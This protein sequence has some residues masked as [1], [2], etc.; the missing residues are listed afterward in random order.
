M[1]P[2]RSDGSERDAAVVRLEFDRGTILCSHWPPSIDP[3]GL[4]GMRW[5]ERVGCFRAPARFHEAVRSALRAAA[6][7]CESLVLAPLPPPVPRRVPE[8]RPYQEAAVATW[9]GGGARGVIVLPTGS[10]KTRVAVAAIARQRC[11]T[12][13]LV[14]TRVLLEQWVD[15][16][17]RELGIGV[18]RHGD[19]ARDTRPVTVAT[20]A[21]AR[22]HMPQLGRLFPLLV[23]DE[24]HHFGG[25]SHDA[26]DMCAASW[27][28]GLTATPPEGAPRQKLDE[29]VGPIVFEL[30]IADLAGVYLSE[31]EQIKLSVGLDAL[32]QSAYAA[33]RA[34]FAGVWDEFRA[35]SPT[36]GWE[37]FVRWAA[38][39]PRGREAFR[40]WRR[41]RTLLALTRAKSELVG[42][43]LAA[44]SGAR[45][46]VFTA[47]AVSAHRIAREHLIPPITAEIKK[48]ERDAMLAAFRRGD[49]RAL[50]SAR[51]LNEGI[52][53]PDADVGIVVS[54]A[55]GVREHVQRL[56]RLLRPRAGKRAILYELVTRNTF[57]TAQAR[58]RKR[59][60]DHAGAA[61]L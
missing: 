8:L 58:R 49:V 39:T 1:P 38:R 50:V 36:S 45:T 27:R 23:V 28:M 9:H 41:A 29:L 12:L 51:V 19:G 53:V 20:F 14:P 2:V 3:A 48:G 13:C 40:C 55:L 7:A 5:D 4:P 11:A 31:F 52:D 43:L 24:A 59:G 47:D 15:V 21:S 42:T 46:L 25:G 26:L 18:G 17:Q 32:E 57:E 35:F 61:P 30:S 54:G 44:H 33:A 34:G 6:V 10:G 56:G 37:D 16:L 60:V 22:L